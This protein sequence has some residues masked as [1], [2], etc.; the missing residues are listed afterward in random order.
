MIDNDRH[1][2]DESMDVGQ[3]ALKTSEFFEIL[4]R[5]H[6]FYGFDLVRVK[7][8]FFGCDNESKKFAT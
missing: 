6:I 7:M 3:P 1:I 4:W 8:N 2:Y 5:L